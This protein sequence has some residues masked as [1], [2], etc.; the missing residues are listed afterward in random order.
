MISFESLVPIEV[1]FELRYPTGYLYWDSY[2]K[3]L[4]IISGK[5]NGMRVDAVGISESIVSIPEMNVTLKYSPQIIA[6]TITESKDIKSFSE[7]ADFTVKTI[8][9]FLE[10]GSFSRI[11]NRFRFMKFVNTH[12]EASEILHKCNLLNIPKPLA[13]QH[14]NNIIQ[15][16]KCSLYDGNNYGYNFNFAY[17]IRDKNIPQADNVVPNNISSRDGVLFD[18]DIFTTKP[19]ALS[20]LDCAELIKQ[21]MKD[22]EYLIKSFYNNQ[23]IL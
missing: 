18:I 22:Y 23:V 7:F 16:I 5:Y 3:I 21:K 14:G 11:G 20:T 12:D 10:I 2:G 6:I 15:E 8:C 19:V 13:D 4:N 9:N 17:L 1:D